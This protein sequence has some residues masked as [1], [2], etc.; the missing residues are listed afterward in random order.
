MRTATARIHGARSVSLSVAA[1][2]CRET[3]HDQH[4]PV[5]V[6]GPSQDEVVIIPWPQEA[7]RPDCNQIP[8]AAS[9]LANVWKLANGNASSTSGFHARVFTSCV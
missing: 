7:Q 9:R 4:Y 8:A 5:K 2:P 3:D 1:K 6:P